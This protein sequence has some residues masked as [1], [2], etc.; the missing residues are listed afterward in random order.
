MG[1]AKYHRAYLVEGVHHVGNELVAGPVSA[2]DDVPGACGRN[3]FRGA[4]A[5]GGK[6]GVPKGL[7]HQLGAGLAVGVG[8]VPS[9]AVGLAVAPNPLVVLV[10]LVARDVDHGRLSR[11]PSSRLEQVHRPH[12]VGRIGVDRIFIRKPD[13]R[14]RRQMKDDVRP[15]LLEAFAQPRVIPDVAG[16]GYHAGFHVGDLV[17]AGYGR[18][19]QRVAYDARRQPLQ[20]QGKPAS[21]ETG[22]ARDEHIPAFPEAWIH[23]FPSRFQA[24]ASGYLPG[25]LPAGFSQTFQG[26]SPFPFIR[27]NVILSLK[28]SMAAQNPWCWYE[29]SCRFSIRRRNGSSTSSSPALIWSNMSR[30]KRKNPPLSQK[31]ESRM[32]PKWLTIPSSPA[33]TAW[34]DCQVL[35]A[36]KLAT[37]FFFSQAFEYSVRDRSDSASL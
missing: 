10:S 19:R 22:M 3:R 36:T 15:V 18:G 14:L 4:P 33:V 20:P 24:P 11:E 16:Y 28:V 9:E 21:L 5:G 23:R 7:G 32:G 13:H 29:Y 31:P 26:V 1:V 2:S 17:Q 6:E 37:V 12:H 25:R 34:K 35:T 27:S 30:L 8:V